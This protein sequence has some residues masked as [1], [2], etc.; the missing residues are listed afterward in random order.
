MK[1]F[2]IVIPCYNEANRF[3]TERFK[4][5]LKNRN[6]VVLFFVDD[7]STDTTSSLIKALKSVFPEQV[8]SIIH[9]KN[10]GK[11]E[12]VRT[13]INEAFKR[14]DIERFA[15]LDADLSS[16]LEEC[17]EIAD[18]IDTHKAFVFGSRIKK[19]DNN[20]QRK[21][22]RFIIG[23]VIAT[24]ISYM[25]KL[26]IYDS[27]CGCKV[28][29]RDWVGIIFKDVFISPWLFD[30]EIFFRLIRHFGRE[31]IQ[32]KI[33]EVPLKEWVDTDDSKVSLLYGFKVW[34]DLIKIYVH[35]K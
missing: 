28:F 12:A 6:G 24:L 15:F 22:Y 3:Q 5:F 19:L 30:V 13:G 2:A 11:A 10:K 27:Q 9:L 17:F 25:L 1:S 21:K 4:A 29:R 16:S 32:T 33:E 35:Y 18:K 14:K 34:F 7:G 8:Q 26:P 23:R 31:K 20:I